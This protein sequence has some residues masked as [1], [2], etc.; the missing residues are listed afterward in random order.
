MHKLFLKVP[1]TK[2]LSRKVLSS[3]KRDAKRTRNMCGAWRW[4]IV[5]PFGGNV[6]VEGLQKRKEKE[7]WM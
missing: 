2:E 5:L 4:E 3:L 1:F 7:K 6:N